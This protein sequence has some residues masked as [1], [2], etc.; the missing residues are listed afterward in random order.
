MWI[1]IV[2]QVYKAWAQAQELSCM[3]KIAKGHCATAR[4]LGASRLQ[5]AKQ[6]GICLM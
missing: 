1:M 6:P 2:N 3:S 5:M 4:I